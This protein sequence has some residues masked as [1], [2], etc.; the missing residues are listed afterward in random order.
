MATLT[1]GLTLASTDATADVLSV[2]LSDSLT[3][4]LPS[5][6]LSRASIATTGETN[7]LTTADSGISYVYIRNTDGT[8]IVTAKTD[9]AVSVMDIGP[10]EFA[11]FPL[12]GAVGL[13]LTANSAACIVEYAYWT[14]G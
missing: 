3:T 8:N 5:V 9:G 14:K 12:K 10:G 13:E 11:F 6:G 4:A 7:I 1:V 2:S